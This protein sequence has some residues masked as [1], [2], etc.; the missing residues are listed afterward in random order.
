LEFKVN[1]TAQNALE[2]IKEKKYAD[3]YLNQNKK[4][5]LIGI[6]FEGK[7]IKEYVTEELK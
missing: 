6:S 2:Q 4:I 7:G 3:K 5:T 1:N